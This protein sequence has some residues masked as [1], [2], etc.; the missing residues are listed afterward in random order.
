[1]EARTA[2]IGSLVAHL[3]GL[4]VVASALPQLDGEEHAIVADE[5]R[6]SAYSVFVA[7]E[8]PGEPVEGDGVMGK[9]DGPAQPTRHALAGPALVR[10]RY[11]TS[12]PQD[13]PLIGRG[14]LGPSYVVAP[15][16]GLLHAPTWDNPLDGHAA[17][18]ATAEGKLRG[19]DIADARGENGLGA[20]DRRRNDRTTTHGYRCRMP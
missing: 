5:Q 7:S 14:P 11:A 3:V 1:M 2:I 13:D 15:H 6:Y 18:N 10:D 12:H 8:Q 19:V 4:A 17:D 20:P 16:I 9:I